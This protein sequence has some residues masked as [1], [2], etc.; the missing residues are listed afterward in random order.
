MEYKGRITNCFSLLAMEPWRESLKLPERKFP[1][2]CNADGNSSSGDLLRELNETMSD[3]R[4]VGLI[5]TQ[6]M[7]IKHL[8]LYHHHWRHHQTWEN[9][10]I[11]TAS[12]GCG[13]QSSDSSNSLHLPATPLQRSYKSTSR[14]GVNAH[15]VSSWPDFNLH[16]NYSYTDP[17]ST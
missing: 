12:Q 7:V 2:L 15:P 1:H 16:P 11:F 4:V 5:E 3:R 17:I 10:F 14:V 6:Q 9:T 13:L 8:H